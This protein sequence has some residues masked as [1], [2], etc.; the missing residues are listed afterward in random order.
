MTEAPFIDT[1]TSTAGI[2][3][4]SISLNSVRRV[5]CKVK[6]AYD[7]QKRSH[8]IK[9]EDNQLRYNSSDLNNTLPRRYTL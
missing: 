2:V 7:G 6:D 8:F 5:T 1:M 3:A 4:F 9:I